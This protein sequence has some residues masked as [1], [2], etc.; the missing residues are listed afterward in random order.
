MLADA[1]GV[2]EDKVGIADILGERVALPAQRPDDELAVE[3]VHLATDGF[4]VKLL[5]HCAGSFRLRRRSCLSF[6]SSACS[7]SVVPTLREE[8]DSL[9]LTPAFAP[10]PRCDTTI[11]Y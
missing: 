5:R 10:Q 4:D 11:A 7:T 9:P 1:T 3:H 2:E 6:V 8:P